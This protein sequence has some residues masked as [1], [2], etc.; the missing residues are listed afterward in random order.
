MKVM[1]TGASGMVGRN[2]LEQ[3]FFVDLVAAGSLFSPSSSELDLRRRDVLTQYFVESKPDVV[4]HAAGKV[5]GIHANIAAP[6]EFLLTNLDMGANLISAARLAGVPRI[7]NLGSSCMYPKNWPERLTE[8]IILRGELEP[9]NEGYALAKIVVAKLG[10]Y[11]NR[12][13]DSGV[14]VKTL[15]PCNLYGW[16]D[17]FDPDQSHLI[18]AIIHK[19]HEAKRLKQKSVTIWGDGTAAREFMFAGDLAE[20]LAEAVRRFDELPDLLNVGTGVDYSVNQYYEIIARALG[21][22]G[23]F[24]HDLSKPPGMM[25][26][27][28]NIDKLK[29]WGWTAPT[30]IEKGVRQTVSYFRKYVAE[31]YS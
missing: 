13:K 1:I 19:I 16:W 10:E 4:I 23:D 29:S 25:R 7:L 27:L 24:N 30:D 22:E 21:F 5:G 28:M 14:C 17:N 9:T 31:S 3:P 2:I 26:K 15:I 11:S 6:Y 18:A 20:F 8:D 12:M